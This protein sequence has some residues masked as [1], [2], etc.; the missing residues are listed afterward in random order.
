VV[1]PVVGLGLVTAA[2]AYATGIAAARRL[3]PALAAGP[4]LAVAPL[5]RLGPG[6]AGSRSTDVPGGGAGGSGSAGL[7]GHAEGDGGE[8]L[9][10]FN[11]DGGGAAY[12]GSVAAVAHAVER[13]LDAVQRDPRAPAEGLGDLLLGR[14]VARRRSPQVVQLLDPEPALL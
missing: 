1:A 3:G 5:R 9:E 13:S 6:V 12:A 4:D 2:L 14:V 8:D 7:A 11:R 10:A